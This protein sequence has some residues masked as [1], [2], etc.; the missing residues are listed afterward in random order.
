VDNNKREIFKKIIKSDPVFSSSIS[1]EACDIVKKLL[2]KKIEKRIKPEDIPNH[3][4]F[5]NLDFA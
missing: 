4:F 1:L 3:P 2:N 5:R